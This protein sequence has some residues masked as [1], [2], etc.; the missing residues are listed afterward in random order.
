[1]N[2]IQQLIND[3]VMNALGWSIIHILWQGT[4]LALISALVLFVFRHK[5]SRLRYFILLSG[6]FLF[7]GLSVTNFMYQLENSKQSARY[8]AVDFT[9][10]IQ[11]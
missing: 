6:L 4:V 11:T 10:K 3:S 5:S 8:S 1:M 7:V 9:G 2:I